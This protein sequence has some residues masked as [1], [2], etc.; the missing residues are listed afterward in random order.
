[1]LRLLFQLRF[2]KFEFQILKPPIR[3]EFDL[4]KPITEKAK[5]AIAQLKKLEE[6]YKMRNGL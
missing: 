5:T 1:M 6:D 4:L 3:K 2:Q